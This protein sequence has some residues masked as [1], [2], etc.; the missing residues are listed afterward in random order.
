M[1]CCTPVAANTN[2]PAQFVEGYVPTLQ[3]L[4][5]VGVG[6][7]DLDDWSNFATGWLGMQMLE[8]S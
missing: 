7:N 1:L 4:G 8:K 3:S 6:A 5:Y 2:G